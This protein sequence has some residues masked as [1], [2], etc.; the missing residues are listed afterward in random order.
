MC[1][2]EAA[3]DNPFNPAFFSCPNISMLQEGIFD[4]AV[5]PPAIPTNC[6]ATLVP[7]TTKD[8]MVG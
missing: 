5:K 2:I 3:R 8:G 1:G 7:V 4:R 6:A